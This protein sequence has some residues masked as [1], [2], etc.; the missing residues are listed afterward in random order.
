[1]ALSLHHDKFHSASQLSCL[2]RHCVELLAM[3]HVGISWH[4]QLRRV[5][6]IHSEMVH[7]LV[8]THSESRGHL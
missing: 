1:M 6:R 8:A 4:D 5:Y 3:R 2:G 7:V